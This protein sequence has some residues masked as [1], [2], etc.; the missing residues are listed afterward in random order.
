MRLEGPFWG[1]RSL[2]L[3]SSPHP[4]PALYEIGENTGSENSEWFS[5]SLH[6]LC[7][8]ISAFCSAK[9]LSLPW[10]LAWLGPENHL[11]EFSQPLLC[12]LAPLWSLFLTQGLF[13]VTTMAAQ[14][15]QF[16]PLPPGLWVF[17]ALS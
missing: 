12:S 13:S 15:L 16:S 14:D 6:S 1:I 17:R 2:H 10:L 3:E 11:Q 5:A 4:P 9:A 8:L 7:S